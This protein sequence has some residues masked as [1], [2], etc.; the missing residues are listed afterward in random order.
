MRSSPRSRA[1]LYCISNSIR[2]RAR[3]RPRRR[4][5][6]RAGVPRDRRRRLRP[7][8]RRR[9]DVAQA[10]HDIEDGRW[11]VQ[12]LPRVGRAARGGDQ[13]RARRHPAGSRPV[14]HLLEQRARTPHR[15]PG[16]RRGAQFGAAV[17]AGAYLVEQAN[18][19]H[20]HEWT[21]WD[22]IPLPSDKVLVPGV[23]THHT[24][25]VENPKARR[26]AARADGGD[27]R[28][29]TGDGRHG[30]RVRPGGDHAPRPRMDAVGEVALAR[31]GAALANEALVAADAKGGPST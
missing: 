1:C 27:P 13:P 8:G 18:V 4:G 21:V 6:A 19:R 3:V 22:D 31:P 7:A 9:G 20:E 5:R 10:G 26:P 14:P 11:R 12:R 28:P 25:V 23:V 29:R 16:N 2:V 17:N 24:E 15:G 30:L